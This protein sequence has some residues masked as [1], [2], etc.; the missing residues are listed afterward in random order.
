VASESALFALAHELGIPVTAGAR[1]EALKVWVA[2]LGIWVPV[3]L[4]L[5]YVVATVLLVPGMI[6]TLVAGALFGLVVGTVTISVG[7]TLGAAA[8]FLIAWHLA[9]ERIAA[10]AARNRNFGAIDRAIDEGGW[11]IVAMLRLSPAIPFNLQNYLYGL[12][13]IGFW[14]YVIASW[15][16]MLPG[17]FSYLY[18][19][20]ITGA[21]V[22][23]DRTRTLAEWAVLAIGLLA[24]VA[25]T[26]YVARLV[27][28][29]LQAK[30]QETPE[31]PGFDSTTVEVVDDGLRS[32]KLS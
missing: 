26:V 10:F 13:P 5:L 20:H 19:G 12:T 18:L 7:L 11:K 29:K 24:T 4:A 2:A 14:P 25:C 9:R 28:K 27:R 15:L 8:A 23:G 31:E 32:R 17:T 22:V 30:M 21:A 16:A 1:D 6:L 3:A